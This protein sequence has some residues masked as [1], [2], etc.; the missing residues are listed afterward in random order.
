MRPLRT[1]A[2]SVLF[3]L[4]V[5]AIVEDAFLRR[6]RDRFC[7]VNLFLGGSFS[8][9]MLLDDETD[10]IRFYGYDHGKPFRWQRV[11]P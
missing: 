6:E 8:S 4:T 9:C 1:I 7:N 3:T 10:H 11:K 5:A 2:L